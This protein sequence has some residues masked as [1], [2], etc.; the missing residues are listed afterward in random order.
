MKPTVTWV[1]LADTQSARIVMN[2]GPGKGFEGV[3]G[4]EFK[5]PPAAEFADIQGRGHSRQGPG[6]SAMQGAD[7]K[8]RATE[9]FAKT[10]ADDLERSATRGAFDRLVLVAGPK[11]LS[12][13]RDAL[14][15]PVRDRVLSEVAKDLTKVR[16]E[17]LPDH[18]G[19]VLAA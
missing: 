7:P 10:I 9:I 13:L 15:K 12:A 17:D 4:K 19:E 1:L 2:T 5:A 16:L 6:R 3:A 18:L 11:M 8:V 14:P